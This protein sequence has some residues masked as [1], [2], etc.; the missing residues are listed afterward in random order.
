[1]ATYREIRYNRLTK[2][3]FP[4]W[5]AKRF[6]DAGVPLRDPALKE[7][8]KER[9]SAWK[10]AKKAGVG[11]RAF[12]REIGFQYETEGFRRERRYRPLEHFEKY[13]ETPRV[14]AAVRAAR[15]RRETP[16]GY[17]GRFRILKDAHFFPWEARLLARMKE[18]DPAKRRDTFESKPWQAMIK[19]HPAYVERMLGKA[20]VRV[21]KELGEKRF[22]ETPQRVL[23]RMA[24][25]KL[26]D[27]LLRAYAAGRYSPWDWIKLSYRPKPVPKGYQ[28][29]KRRRASARVQKLMS[30]GRRVPVAFWE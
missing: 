19:N 9:R 14:V 29:T 12:A 8:R 24:R 1:M 28:V 16:A 22:R 3:G 5:E 21:R 2:E 23:A 7:L 26:E 25:A 10:E 4:F 6:S 15:I 13:K 27:M 18:I 30:R 20:L 11:R 17:E